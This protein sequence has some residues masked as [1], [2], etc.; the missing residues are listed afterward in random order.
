MSGKLRVS[1]IICAH[2]PRRHYLTRVLDA[3]NG[4]S[5]PKENWELLLI[6]NASDTLL[7]NYDL[8]WHPHARHVREDALGLTNARLTGIRDSAADL[9]V[10]V[11]DDNV[12]ASDYLEIALTLSEKW[13]MLGAFSGNIAGEFESEPPNWTREYFGYLTIVDTKK[14]QWSNVM[15]V[16]L[17]TPVGAGMCIRKGIADH[18]RTNVLKDERRRSLGRTGT[19]LAASEDA[20]MAYTACD[21]GFGCGRFTSLRITHLIPPGRLEEDYLVRIVRESTYSGSLLRGFRGDSPPAPP[22]RSHRLFQ[23][24]IRLRLSPRSRRFFDAIEDGRRAASK[25]LSKSRL[26]E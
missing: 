9:L 5:L 25:V 12:L 17:T 15:Y 10:F 23:Q 13:P 26:A 22:G 6:D 24:Y 19:S 8:S 1:V 2:N 21:M 4:Q 18:Y 7:S 14:D 20:D 3:L 11:D 16:G